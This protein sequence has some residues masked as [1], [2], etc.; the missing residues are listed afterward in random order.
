MIKGIIFDMDGVIIDSNSF[1]YE[2]WNSVFK[3]KFN[4]EI[5]K[6]EFASRLGE[7]AIHFT[8]FFVKKYEI[9]KKYKITADKLLPEIIEK[10]KNI[11]HLKLKEGIKE[12]L[13]ELKKSYKIALA[14]GAN[15]DWALKVLEHFDIKNYF[16]FVIAGNEVKRAKP[17]PEIFIKAAQGLKLKANEC[18]VIEDAE[19]GIIAAKKAGC[20]VISIPDE[21]TKKQDHELADLQ[22]DSIKKLDLKNLKDF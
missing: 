7:S 8:E 20:F 3:E 11:S 10:Y 13:P 21:M 4:I 17:E 6:E 15:K 5:P 19:L 16:D 22:L 12:K 9:D 1:H 14:T 18:V 2:N